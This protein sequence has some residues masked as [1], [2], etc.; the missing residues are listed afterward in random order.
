MYETYLT[1]VGRLVTP[2]DKRRLPNGTTVVSFRVASN[3]RRL[4]R[5]ADAWSD[6]DSLFVSVTCWR[7]LGENVHA[8]FVP[9]DPIIVRGRLHSREYDDKDGKHRS[10]IELEGLA[11]GPDLS[12]STAK[13]TRVRRDGSPAVPAA[14]AASPADDAADDGGSD[15]PW[16]SGDDTLGEASGYGSPYAGG[17]GAPVEAAVGV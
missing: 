15:D 7:Q 4:D 13:I 12:S 9:G 11:V 17:A 16:K 1:V 10:V 8:S 3:E 2:V 14:N 5:A 6:G